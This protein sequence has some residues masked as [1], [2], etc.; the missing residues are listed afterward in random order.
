MKNKIFQASKSKDFDSRQKHK[1]FETFKFPR[2]GKEI[3]IWER[4]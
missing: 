1:V 2:N 4:E 3:L